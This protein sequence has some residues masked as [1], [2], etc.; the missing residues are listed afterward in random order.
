MA[1]LITVQLGLLDPLYSLFGLVLGTLYTWLNSYGLVIILFTILIRLVLMPL[2]LRS[3][4]S[5]LR[6][7]MLQPEVNEI[8]RRYG[9]DQ[10]R[11]N[12]LTQQL[13]KEN[14]I[15]MMSGC[16]PT[17]LQLVVIWPIIYIFRAPLRF[18][19]SVDMQNIYKIANM[20]GDKGLMTAA[21]VKNVASMDIPVLNG[22]NA[23]GSALQQSVSNGWIR[24]PQFI[25]T[26]FLGMDLGM[27]PSYNPLQWFGS[28]WQIQLPLVL[29]IIITMLTYFFQMRIMRKSTARPEKTKEEKQREKA[30][31]AKRGQ[32]PDPGAGMMKGMNLFMPLI[33][34]FTM[35]SMPASMCLY[36]LFQNVMYLIQSAL[37]YQYY[38]KPIRLAHAAEQAVFDRSRPGGSSIESP[39]KSGGFKAFFERLRSKKD[40]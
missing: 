39:E 12:E 14:G 36:W 24:L 25:D 3:Q 17:L 16:L 31:P 30:N 23:S 13:Y 20:L 27:T 38:V 21:Q 1:S 19:S 32:D 8:K 5:T 40:D 2:G 4:R 26:K 11:V 6:Q 15:S 18:I 33:M 9:K 10:A 37:G 29:L 22:L 28:Q 35:F 7:Q 34:L